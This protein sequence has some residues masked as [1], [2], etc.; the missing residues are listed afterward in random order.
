M[1]LLVIGAGLLGTKLVSIGNEIGYDVW[2]ADVDESVAPGERFMKVDITNRRTVEKIFEKINPDI[3]VHTAAMTNVDMCDINPDLAK[4]VNVHGTENVARICAAMKIP[5]TYISTDFV[6]DGKKGMYREDDEVNP[7]NVYGETK[8]LGELEVKKLCD[9]Y[10][11]A[12]TSVLYGYYMKRFNFVMWIIKE[13]KMRKNIRIVIDQYGSPT[14][15]NNLAEAILKMNEKK[16]NG[17]YHVA[18]SERINRYDFAV[19]VADVFD[20][21]ESLIT[22]IKTNEL[23]QKAKR[24]KDSSL[25]VSKIESAGIKMYDILTGLKVVKDE[26]GKA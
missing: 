17:T 19:K 18:G 10:I 25:N 9:D 6:F 20:L 8:Y 12:R 23:N 13:L 24:P 15:A 5:M 7:I 1:H 26:E 22:P 21:N 14:L 16:M 4:K 2:S 3:V 11:I